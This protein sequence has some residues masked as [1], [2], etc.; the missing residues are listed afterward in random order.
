MERLSEYCIAC[1]LGYGVEHILYVVQ[2]VQQPF[3][4]FL[5][6]QK[7]MLPH[8]PHTCFTFDKLASLYKMWLLFSNKPFSKRLEIVIIGRVFP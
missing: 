8:R 2:V 1:I 4:A 3:V 6:I 5:Q 7:E